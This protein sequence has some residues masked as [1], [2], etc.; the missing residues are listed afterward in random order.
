MPDSL[1]E[2]WLDDEPNTPEGAPHAIKE[3]VREWNAAYPE[4]PIYVTRPQAHRP[5]ITRELQ[6]QL[7]EPFPEQAIGILPKLAC[8]DCSDAPG[9]VCKAHKKIK[10]E[11]CGN[12]ISERHVHLD[13]VGHAYV[14]E[15]L[16][17]VDPT[18]NWQPLLTDQHGQP[19]HLQGVFWIRLTV[20]GVTRL[21]VGDAAKKMGTGDWWKEAYGDALRNAA[22]R[23]GVAVQLWQR[24]RHGAAPES[25]TPKEK[26]QQSRSGGPRQDSRSSSRRQAPAQGKPGGADALTGKLEDI[27]VKVRKRFDALPQAQQKAWVATFGQPEEL[28]ASMVRQAG[29][30]L[31]AFEMTAATAPPPDEAPAPPAEEHPPPEVEGRN[32]RL[33]K[34]MVGKWSTD[35]LAAALS[36]QGVDQPDDI[37]EARL[38]MANLVV[39]WAA[40]DFPDGVP[41][42]DALVAWW[43]EEPPAIESEPSGGED[44]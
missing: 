14:T 44:A 19:A 29:P 10:C 5:W 36:A 20:C 39:E 1:P 23:F 34:E 32:F 42:L 35:D 22:M 37:G 4:D 27:R 9:K 30:A 26:P 16:L 11:D 31:A 18:W 24:E 38:A 7:M 41:D 6:A 28:K 43:E 8:R 12:W 40:E 15:R 33:A 17:R 3:L 13:Y 21:G 25:Y 2:P